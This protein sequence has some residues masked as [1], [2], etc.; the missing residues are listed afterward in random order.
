MF[1]IRQALLDDASALLK[2][3]RM[4][5]SNN[6]PDDAEILR[7]KIIRSRKSFSE[8]DQLTPSER[9][10]IFVLEDTDTGNVI[11]GSSIIASM[12][13]PDRPNLHLKVRKREFYSEDLQTGQVHVTLQLCQDV[14][15]PTEIGG[16]ILAP[17]YRG[18]QEKLGSLLSLVRF[19]FMGLRRTWF[20]NRIIAEMMG[21]LTP[22]SRNMLWDYL[23]RRFINLSYKEADRFCRQSAEFITSL[24]PPEEVYASLLPPEARRL[25]GRVG[26]E[27]EPAKSLLMRLGFQYMGD[28]DPF[29]GGPYLESK[30]DDIDLVTSTRV[31]T[32]G[33]PVDEFSEQGILSTFEHGKFKSIRSSY[34][35]V[36]EHISIPADAA[37]LLNVEPGD[38]LG[39]TPRNPSSSKNSSSTQRTGAVEH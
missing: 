28:V 22:D 6:L 11:G 31:V 4:V 36:G 3:A 7:T 30:I 8:G 17:G 5:N 10:F 26:P 12:G 14:S 29:D 25:I 35:L 37:G 16:L 15:G 33:D 9:E 23:G 19:H 32:L 13:G 39:F 34:A 18:H 21:T 38:E 2:L 24:F 27:T 20:A 1:Y